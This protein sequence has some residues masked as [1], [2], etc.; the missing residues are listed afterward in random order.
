MQNYNLIV[1]QLNVFLFF[2]KQQIVKK[3]GNNKQGNVK[4]FSL[5]SPLSLPEKAP[6]SPQ[7]WGKIFAIRAIGT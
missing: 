6:L 5:T 3:T 1:T 2:Y 7:K 4:S